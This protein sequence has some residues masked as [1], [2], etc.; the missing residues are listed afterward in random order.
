MK[1]GL[2]ITIYDKP[3]PTLDLAGAYCTAV[4]QLRLNKAAKIDPTASRMP[5][6]DGTPISEL[7]LK[8]EPNIRSSESSNFEWRIAISKIVSMRTVSGAKTDHGQ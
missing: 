4:Y 8:S 6:M 7:R 3:L 5:S 1:R 2:S